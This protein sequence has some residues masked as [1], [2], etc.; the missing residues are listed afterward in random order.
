[1]GIKVLTSRDQRRV[2]ANGFASLGL[3]RSPMSR[4]VFCQFSARCLSSIPFL[5]RGDT[6]DTALEELPIA[7]ELLGGLVEITAIGGE[8]GLAEGN[9]R[10]TGRTREARDEFCEYN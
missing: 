2:H 3:F 9:N 4:S 6:L 7:I 8:G 5:P 10:S 1:M